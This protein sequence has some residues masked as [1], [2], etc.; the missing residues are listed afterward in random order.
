MRINNI[1]LKAVALSTSV[2]AGPLA[3]AGCQQ[4]CA[5]SLVLGPAGPPVYAACQAACASL[6]ALPCP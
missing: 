5:T 3:Y 1:L 6:L 4:A 2:T